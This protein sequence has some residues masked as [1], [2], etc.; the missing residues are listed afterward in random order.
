MKTTNAACECTRTQ[1]CEDSRGGREPFRKPLRERGRGGRDGGQ[2]PRRSTRAAAVPQPVHLQTPRRVS[3]RRQ[4]CIRRPRRD[5]DAG[6]G[7]GLPSARTGTSRS[8][9]SSNRS[10]HRTDAPASRNGRD[11]YSEGTLN[12]GQRRSD[13]APLMAPIAGPLRGTK[14]G[15]ASALGRKLPSGHEVFNREFLSLARDSAEHHHFHAMPL[16]SP[17]SASA[18]RHSLAR[19]MTLV[20]SMATAW[21][22]LADRRSRAQLD[23][24]RDRQLLFNYPA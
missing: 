17:F 24:S 19:V 7:Q 18:A 21:S 15:S 14:F 5:R 6:Q 1:E 20:R 4:R 23:S 3:R 12:R 10:L 16:I 9:G 13:N 11:R 2:M 8:L 22:A